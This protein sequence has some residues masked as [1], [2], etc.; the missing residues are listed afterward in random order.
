MT[1]YYY[2]KQDRKIQ[3][4]ILRLLSLALVIIGFAIASYI[5]YPLISWQVYFAPV[6]ASG[7]FVTSIPR[8][9]IVNSSQINS[10]LSQAGNLITGTDY[11]NAQNWFPNFRPSQKIKPKIS[12]YSIYIP[13][14]NIESATVSTIDYDLAA[15][16]VNYEGTA[17]PT[18]KGTA[19]IFGHS[20]LPQ[21]FNPKDYKA[22]F[23]TLYQLRVGDEIYANV[24]GVSY[25]YKVFNINVVEPTDISIFEQDY[26][27]SYITLVTC[28]PP[29]TT[30]KR[31][32]VKARLENI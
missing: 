24:N 14:L 22:I 13:K 15:H 8:T 12:S 2:T 3:K 6:F 18:E 31:L 25:R 26:S 27:N 9:N 5:F 16:L 7:N 32:I 4:K 11:T 10:L 1:K 20:T 28:T 23:A 29:G 21:L 17:I 30:W 19:V